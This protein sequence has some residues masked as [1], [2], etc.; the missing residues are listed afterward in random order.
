VSQKT[1]YYSPW[2]LYETCPQA[3]LWSRGWGKIDVGGG[4]GRGKPKPV[5]DSRHHAV[6]GIAIGAAIESLYRDELWRT[7]HGLAERLVEKVEKEFLYEISRSFIDWRLA[8]SKAEMLESCRS[9]V[10]GYL[11]T[12]KHQR[13]LGPYAQAEV[14]LLGYVNK[15]TPVGGRA[16]II[17]RRDDTGV[18]ILD[19][20][21]SQSKGK[22][23]DPDQVRWYAL[24]YYLAYGK[25]PDRLGFVYYRYPYGTPK[26]DGTVEEGVDWIPVT[27]TDLEGLAAR[28]VDA[29]KAMSKEQFAPTPS[30]QACKFCDFETVCDARKEQKAA[31][32]RGRKKSGD[33]FGDG[34]LDLKM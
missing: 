3:F 4:P 9:G 13:L 30:P 23:T 33:D 27:R 24:C 31:N 28:A 22:Y 25:L 29:S 21:N 26:E 12:M 7:P 2:K 18:T 32:S 19:G 8:P 34:F 14:E 17:I 11:R 1:L 10:I 15:Y 5:K 16:D 6:M 20:K